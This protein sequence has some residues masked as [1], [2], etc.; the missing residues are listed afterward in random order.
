MEQS[1]FL[2]EIGEENVFDG[3]DESLQRASEIIG[4]AREVKKDSTE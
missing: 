2:D 1:Q 3:I 4:F